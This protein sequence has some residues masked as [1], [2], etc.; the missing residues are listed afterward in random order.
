MLFFLL[1]FFV[2]LDVLFLF[3]VVCL[4]CFLNDLCF[5][6]IMFEYEVFGEN[7]VIFVWVIGIKDEKFC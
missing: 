3:E 5:F 4:F 6:I 7:C 2:E 1:L